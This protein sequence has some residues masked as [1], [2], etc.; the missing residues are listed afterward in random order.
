MEN[1]LELAQ[2][3]VLCPFQ[4]DEQGLVKRNVVG[5]NSFDIAGMFGSLA[6]LEELVVQ[7]GP[8]LRMADLSKALLAA[9]GVRGGSAELVQRLLELRVDANVQ[10]TM[11]SNTA[12]HVLFTAKS[13][14][15]RCSK[16]TFMTTWAYHL[17]GQTA[18]MAAVMSG[19]YEAA[20]A[21]VAAGAKL[22]LRNS[23]NWT[24]ADFAKG[25]PDASAQK[26]L[27]WF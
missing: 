5:M 1:I 23:R 26:V 18:L 10:A 17:G 12:A 25:F 8:H 16:A 19:Q 21:L 20:A 4:L 3:V 13:I 7:V 27:T 24:A 22:D 14:Q 2:M 6:A 9:T 11:S 15:H